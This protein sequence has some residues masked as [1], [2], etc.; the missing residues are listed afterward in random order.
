MIS[1]FHCTSLNMDSYPGHTPTSRW[2]SYGRTSRYGSY[3]HITKAQMKRVQHSLYIG[4]IMRYSLHVSYLS[5]VILGLLVQVQYPVTLTTQVS[6]TVTQDHRLG[7]N[8]IMVITLD[9]NIIMV[10]AQRLGAEQ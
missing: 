2:S 5:H 7:L 1:L 3:S 10:I 4:I 6:T 8:I 9:L